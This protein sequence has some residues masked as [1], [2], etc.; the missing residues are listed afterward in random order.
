MHAFSRRRLLKTGAAFAATFAAPALVRAAPK[1][2][3][4][5]GPAGA[6]KYFN[7]DLFP[8]LEKKLD[9][10]VLYEGTNSLTNLQKM[11]ADKASPKIS[12]VIMDDP[13]ML[14]AAAEGLIT[15]MS[16]SSIPNLG[17]LVGDAVHQDGMWANYQKPWAGIAY[18]TKRV[19]TPPV[20]WA[21]LWDAKYDSKIVVPSLSNTE[22]FWTLLAAAHLE[23]GKPYKEAQYDI[24]AGFKKIK[25]LKA[26]LLNVYTNAPQAINLL[27]Q[28]EAW[29]IGGQFSAYT[30]IRKADG[31]PVDLAIP[32]DGGFSMPSGIAK[33]T[34][35]PAGDLADAVIDFYL[36]PEAQSILAKTAF[37]APTNQATPLPA[38]YPDPASLFAPDWAFIAKN[39]AGWVDR[40]SK[41]M[42]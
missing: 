5:G 28:G 24:D 37:I 33:V 42:T 10:K 19:K 30:L 13:V 18:S 36:S 40:W 20:S 7:A 32:K 2:I 25:S 3:V 29:M 16:S 14:P 17:K 12:V 34:G 21:E 1:E 31:S 15:K 27:E 6:A 8:V 22:G 41:E 35:A 39:R 11:Q 26:N 4:I 38:G 9:C 23:T